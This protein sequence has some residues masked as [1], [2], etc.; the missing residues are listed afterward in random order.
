MVASVAVAFTLTCPNLHRGRYILFPISIDRF[1]HLFILR[2]ENFIMKFSL[3]HFARKFVDKIFYILN[4]HLMSLAPLF[5]QKNVSC[6]QSG[7]GMAEQYLNGR[8]RCRDNADWEDEV[9]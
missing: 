2:Y 9:R 1:I 7:G 5:E 6:A 8:C 4:I 3:F